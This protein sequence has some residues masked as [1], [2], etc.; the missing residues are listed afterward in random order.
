MAEKIEPALTAEEWAENERHS[1]DYMIESRS[2]RCE[3]A[4]VVALANWALDDDP[5]KITRETIDGLLR[6]ADD[7]ATPDRHSRPLYALARALESYLP[8]ETGT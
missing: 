5:R 1:I 2:G 8:P 7:L 3:Y 6:V 4:K